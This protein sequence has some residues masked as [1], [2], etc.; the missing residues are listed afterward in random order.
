MDLAELSAR[1]L[2]VL[3]IVAEFIERYGYSPSIREVQLR[4]QLPSTS[5]T[6]RV[7]GSLRTKGLLEWH[8]RANRTMRIVNGSS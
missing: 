2:Q 4:A 6:H 1:E 7:L 5:S 8:T 3:R